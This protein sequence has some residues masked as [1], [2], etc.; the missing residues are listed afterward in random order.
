MSPKSAAGKICYVEIPSVDPERSSA[1]YSAVFGWELRKRGDGSTAFDDGFG[2]SG[3]WV[4]GRPPS[5]EVGLL[6]YVMC[7]SVSKTVD[8]VVANGGVI[9]QPIGVDAPEI[10]A[11]FRDP[12]GNVIGLYQEPHS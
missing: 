2:V 3:A 4:V 5:R 7:D 8:K 12:G 9:V 11:R 6:L 1:F 10:T